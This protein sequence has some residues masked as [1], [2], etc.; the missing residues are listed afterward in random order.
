MKLV[1]NGVILSG[2]L[3]LVAQPQSPA[4]PA[5][6]GNAIRIVLTPR[7]FEPRE[8]TVK[9]GIVD[10]VIRSRVAGTAAF[11]LV[12]LAGGTPKLNRAQGKASV[13]D[14]TVLT[15]GTYEIRDARFPRWK[16][17]VNVRP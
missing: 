16:C 15:P 4:G 12:D 9:P 6:R 17:V 7:G 13:K 10:L 8:V 5:Q 3:A 1:L 11:Q 2:L 14:R